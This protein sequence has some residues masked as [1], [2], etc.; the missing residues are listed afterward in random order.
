MARVC[1][2]VG[3]GIR[4]NAGDEAVARVEQPAEA[5]EHI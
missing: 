4:G 5:M 1:A 3:W 2:A